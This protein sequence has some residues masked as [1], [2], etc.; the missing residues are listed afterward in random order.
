[1]K[2]KIGVELLRSKLVKPQ[3]KK[4]EIYDTDLKG[5]GLIIYPDVVKGDGQIVP[6]GKIYI[7]R[8]RLSNGKQTMTRIGRHTLFTP[9]QARDEAEKILRKAKDGLDP[10]KDQKLTTSHSFKS[11]LEDEYSPWAEAQRKDGKATVKRLKSR[12]SDF[13]ELP[14]TEITPL[15][16][17]KWR[18]GRLKDSKRPATCN[19]SLIHISEPTRPY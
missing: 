1:M 19:L 13:L 17:D 16:V 18:T 4:F 2:A 3:V 8:Y 9:A 6:G 11:F 5:F 12:F 14:L 7:A 15:I 10:A